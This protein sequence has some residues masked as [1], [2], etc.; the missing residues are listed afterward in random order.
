MQLNFS[1]EFHKSCETK[2]S[3]RKYESEICTET[4]LQ[5]LD[6]C[7]KNRTDESVSLYTSEVCLKN[8]NSK[9]L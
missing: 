8:N 6:V 7:E 5:T 1:M 2:G 4:K 3:L 9:A